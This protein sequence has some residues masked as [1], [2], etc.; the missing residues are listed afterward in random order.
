[1]ENNIPGVFTAANGMESALILQLD[2]IGN[3]LVL[4]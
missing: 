3:G 2:N 1:M 4:Q